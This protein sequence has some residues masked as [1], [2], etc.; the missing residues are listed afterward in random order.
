VSEKVGFVYRVRPAVTNK[1]PN[2]LFAAVWEGHT[3]GDFKPILA[4]S[5]TYVC[6][7]R[8][9]KSGKRLVGFVNVA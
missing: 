2:A 9:W 7:Y 3:E 1:A 4:C 6:A 8:A 5:L